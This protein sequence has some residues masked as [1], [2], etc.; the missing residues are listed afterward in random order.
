MS[1]VKRS[2]LL[3]AP[4]IDAS[5][6]PGLG[7]F[8]S[9][10]ARTSPHC[11]VKGWGLGFRVG[12]STVGVSQFRGFRDFIFSALTTRTVQAKLVSRGQ[13]KNS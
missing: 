4:Y 13:P 7:F 11:R 12:V 3:K 2:E 10:L 8:P 5:W 6:V 9:Y 1:F